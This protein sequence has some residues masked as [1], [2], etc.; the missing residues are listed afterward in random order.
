MSNKCFIDPPQHNESLVNNKSWSH[1]TD[2]C[3]KLVQYCYMVLTDIFIGMAV[4]GVG[5]SVH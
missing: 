1:P 3:M 2:T 5:C 4:S